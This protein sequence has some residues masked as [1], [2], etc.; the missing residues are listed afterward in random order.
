MSEFSAVL[1][2]IGLEKLDSENELRRKSALILSQILSSEDWVHVRL[3]QK[4][5]IGVYYA[6][7]VEINL[8][9]NL[10]ESLL[11]EFISRGVPMRKLF[12]ALNKHPHFN[13]KFNPARGTPWTHPNYDGQM[14]NVT[15][16]NLFFP[17]CDEFC[18]GRVLEL[19]AHPGTTELHLEAFARTLKELYSSISF[20]S[21]SKRS[22]WD[23][24]N[25]W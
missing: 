20:G 24:D 12:S 25:G 8:P 11:K 10:S 21:D 17:K 16:Q 6:I 19:Y 14:K 3:V 7:A 18:N 9:D 15:Y 22:N 1:A 5:E 23:K 13:P 2:R 4:D